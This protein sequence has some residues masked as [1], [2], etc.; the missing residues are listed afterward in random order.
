MVTIYNLRTHSTVKEKKDVLNVSF[1][2][3]LEHISNIVWIMQNL[4]NIYM[5]SLWKFIDIN[6]ANETNW[7]SL[8]SFALTR[9]NTLL[10]FCM[11]NFFPVC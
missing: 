1:I 5:M 11:A 6:I 4:N 3:Y 7:Y 10:F 9:D 8:L 2:F